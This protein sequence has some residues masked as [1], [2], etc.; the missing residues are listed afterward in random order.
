MNEELFVLLWRCKRMSTSFDIQPQS[1]MESYDREQR[2][3]EGG[4]MWELKIFDE[5][6]SA[7]FRTY[8]RGSD[9]N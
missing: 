4:Q 2:I 6:L 3:C 7:L 5:W 9:S 1:S 8:D